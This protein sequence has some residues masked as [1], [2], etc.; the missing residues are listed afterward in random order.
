MG[1]KAILDK[2]RNI[3]KSC[4]DK[5][6]ISGICISTCGMVNADNGEIFYASSAVPDYAGIAF[7][8]V[9]ENEF[10]LPCAKLRMM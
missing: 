1:G 4:I 10:N 5:Y 2:V 8:T 7:K 9:L 6:K 3:V